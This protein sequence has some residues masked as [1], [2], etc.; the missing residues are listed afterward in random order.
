MHAILA[1][2]LLF[3]AAPE[4]DAGQLRQLAMGEGITLPG[5][6]PAEGI[7]L[8]RGGSASYLDALGWRNVLAKI[9]LGSTAIISRQDLEYIARE[10]G[11]K[12]FYEGKPTRAPADWKFF[13]PLIQPVR[14]EPAIAVLAV[15]EN[16]AQLTR[17]SSLEALRYFT[18]HP[19]GNIP[20]SFRLPA[21]ARG[22]VALVLLTRSAA[23]RV[24]QDRV[25]VM[26]SATKG[27]LGG[28]EWS[29]AVTQ[30]D[31]DGDGQLEIALVRRRSRNPALCADGGY[32]CASDL[33]YLAMRYRGV[34]YKTAERQDGQDGP[35]GF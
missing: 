13:P 11:G 1:A 10:S 23:E 15:F 9:A 6:T 17:V 22:A 25:V 35:E 3:L 18:R 31:L 16:R 19:R 28:E 24:A 30:V 32:G 21:E 8:P 26:T 7:G 5:L 20:L 2:A 33:S 27:R 12:I 29:R 4:R 34:W 14:F